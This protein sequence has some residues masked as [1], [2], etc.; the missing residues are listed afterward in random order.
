VLIRDH[1][2]F[3][4]PKEYV[5]DEADRID[6]PPATVAQYDLVKPKTGTSGMLLEGGLTFVVRR[7]ER[8]FTVSSNEIDNL[9]R[10]M[11]DQVDRQGR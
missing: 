2:E 10:T 11:N 4:R 5:T 1:R 7:L 6:L 8:D 3:C 9:L